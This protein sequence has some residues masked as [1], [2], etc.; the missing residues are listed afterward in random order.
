ME[1]KGLLIVIASPSGGGKTS[2]IQKLKERQAELVHSISCTTRPMRKG[3]VNH[4][5]YHHI[6]REEF[7][8]GIKAGEFVEW[9]HV[10]TDLYGTPKAPIDQ[11]LKEGRNVILDLD[12]VGSLNVK[13]I[14]GRRAVTI[15]I[16]PPSIE[17]LKKRLANRRTDPAEA[18]ALRLKN[19][20]EEMTHKD[21][22][23]HNVINDELERV[24]GEIE[25][26][27]IASTARRSP[28][29]N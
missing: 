15:F 20:L 25:R 12:V 5:Y 13:K 6:S 27:V 29:R 4:K 3:E 8:K 17:E 2:V 23:D 18:Q 19:A 21:E 7:E 28:E 10:H 1:N 22:F 24:C 11:W 14:Y 26:I 9:A 16:L